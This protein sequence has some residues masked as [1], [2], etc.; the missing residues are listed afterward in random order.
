MEQMKPELHRFILENSSPLERFILFLKNPGVVAAHEIGKIADRKGREV[1]PSDIDPAISPKKIGE[2]LGLSEDE[3]VRAY[4]GVLERAQA[5][6]K[7]LHAL[8]TI[9]NIWDLKRIPLVPSA[10]AVAEGR[11]NF[12]AR[13]KEGFWEAYVRPGPVVDIGYHGGHPGAQPLFTQAIGL[14]LNT[15]GYNGRDLPYSDSSIGTIHG[16]HFLEHIA[17]YQHFFRE[18]LRVLMNGGTLILMVPLMEAYENRLV[19]PSVHNPDHKRFYTASRL[20]EEFERAL[21]RQ[22]YRIIHLREKFNMADLNRPAGIHAGGP[23]YEIECVVEKTTPGMAYG[24]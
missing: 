5:E 8:A 1:L 12:A 15:P 17:D 10:G 21:P 6:L 3:V 18:A 7:R 14:D 11:R 16:C 23:S 24:A 19:G 20:C 2:L 13:E 4:T 9:T 22:A